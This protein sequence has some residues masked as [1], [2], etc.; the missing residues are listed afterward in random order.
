MI[1]F[2]RKQK[3]FSLEKL[4]LSGF[5]WQVAVVNMI[6]VPLEIRFDIPFTLSPKVGIKLT[7]CV[8][9][10]IVPF[11]WLNLC[12]LKI[13]RLGV[14]PGDGASTTRSSVASSCTL[15]SDWKDTLA[16]AGKQFRM[17]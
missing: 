12:T 6:T 14:H 10:C 16:T 15:S 1:Y 8:L 4:T 3:Y 13:F 11:G 9:L 5:L 2:V 17:E 7:F